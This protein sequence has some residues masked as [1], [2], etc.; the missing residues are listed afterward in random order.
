MARLISHNPQAITTEFAA[1]TWRPPQ[2]SINRPISGEKEP[3]SNSPSD[4]PETTSD[5]DYTKRKRA[6]EVSRNRHA[7]VPPLQQS[8]IKMSTQVDQNLT[9]SVRP[10]G[11]GLTTVC[12]QK[13]EV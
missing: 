12:R 7:I 4:K 13:K 1:I 11:A 5:S 8:R 6:M 9:R 3:V 2:Q 10:F